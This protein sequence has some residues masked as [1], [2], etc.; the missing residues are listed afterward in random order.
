MNDSPEDLTIPSIPPAAP[1]A[2]KE[3]VSWETHSAISSFILQHAPDDVRDTMDAELSQKIG[4]INSYADHAD[5]PRSAQTVLHS[6]FL[7]RLSADHRAS[8][9]YIR[10]VNADVADLVEFVRAIPC[11]P[12]ME[13]RRDAHA[14]TLLNALTPQFRSMGVQSIGTANYTLCEPTVHIPTPTSVSYVPPRVQEEPVEDIP[15]TADWNCARQGEGFRERAAGTHA[16][17]LVPQT[18]PTLAPTFVLENV[19]ATMQGHANGQLKGMAEDFLPLCSRT[20]VKKMA[21]YAEIVHDSQHVRRT[22]PLCK[23]KLAL[24]KR[25]EAMAL[26]NMQ[27]TFA[28]VY[29]FLERYKKWE[30]S[31]PRDSDALAEAHGTYFELVDHINESMRKAGYKQAVGEEGSLELIPRTRE[32]EMEATRAA[33]KSR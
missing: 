16:E 24:N 33:T 30:D 26:E 32:A 1:E 20:L 15:S 19:I 14:N 17:K 21:S 3:L 31:L 12:A 9:A 28:P 10:K 18:Y 7:S 11:P 6:T 27:S 29:H 4:T 25:V 2:R 8:Q 5:L 22:T 13:S 23:D